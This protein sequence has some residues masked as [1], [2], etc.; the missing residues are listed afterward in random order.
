[1]Y[2]GDD[3]IIVNVPDSVGTYSLRVYRLSKPLT[4]APRPGSRQ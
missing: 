4:A 3:R 1:M 2:M